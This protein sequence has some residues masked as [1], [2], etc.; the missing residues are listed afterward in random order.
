MPL[1]RQNKV[2]G[3]YKYHLYKLP[4]H[5]NQ[6]AYKFDIFLQA[7]VDMVTPKSIANNRYFDFM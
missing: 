6:S 4:H 3:Y 1:C 5:Q 7:T 2:V